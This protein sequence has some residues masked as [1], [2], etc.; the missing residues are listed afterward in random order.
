MGRNAVWR[1]YG[2]INEVKFA[3]TC[4]SCSS[5][6]S[7][8]HSE[9]LSDLVKRWNFEQRQAPL[10]KVYE[11]ALNEICLEVQRPFTGLFPAPVESELSEV[12]YW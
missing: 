1:A 11:G 3:L 4:P 5:C 2:D 12:T 7:M 8:K 6:M 10:T 9:T